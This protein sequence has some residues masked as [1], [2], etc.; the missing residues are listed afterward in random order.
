MEGLVLRIGGA[1][2]R[3]EVRK[4]GGEEKPFSPRSVPS[5]TFPLMDHGPKGSVTP[6][7]SLLLYPLEATLPPPEHLLRVDA[8]KVRSNQRLG[9]F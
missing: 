6:A 8:C 2:C 5:S 4:P 1:K 7:S 3:D 9:Q